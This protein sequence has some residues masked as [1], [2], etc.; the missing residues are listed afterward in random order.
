M[1]ARFVANV[2]FP[3]PPFSPSTATIMPT[4]HLAI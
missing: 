2:V 3:V 4:T 1:P